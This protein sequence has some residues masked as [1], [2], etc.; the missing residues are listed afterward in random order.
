MTTNTTAIPPRKAR[1]KDFGLVP[2]VVLFILNAVDE[3]DRAVLSVA[4]EDIREDFGLNDLTVGLLPLAVIFIT[5][6]ISLPA[7]NWA[8]RWKRIYILAGGAIV[9][10]SAGILA[11]TSRNFLQLFLTRA[12]LGFGQGT[13]VP[14]HASLLS[15][16]YPVT[17]RG[18]ALSYHR[19]A[20]PLG[21]VIG[22][23]IGG[24]IVASL[25]WRWA[26]AAAAIPGLILGLYAL[27]LREPRRG[28]SDLIHAAKQDPLFA[29][30]LTDPPDK[31]GFWA[32]LGSIFR[33]PSLKWLILTNAAF[34]FPLF[35]VVFWLPALFEREFGATTE[36]AGA[37]LGAMAFAA[38]LGSWVGGPYSDRCLP[39]GFGYMG[40]V[41]VVAAGTLAVT[42]TL[43]FLMPNGWLCL[44]LLAIGAFVASAGTAGLVAIVAAVSPPRIRS[45]AFSAFGLALAVCGAAAAPV[46]VGGISELLQSA[47]DMESG[48]SLRIAM[49]GATGIVMTVGTFMCQAASR[50][51][52]A[53]VHKTMSEF[54]ADY[55]SRLAAS[56]AAPPP[57][58]NEPSVS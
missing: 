1:L 48:R 31:I 25:G 56:A 42:W 29:A 33:I 46:V 16:Y 37:A 50:T 14:T 21:Q 57:V 5:G 47:A 53:D 15:D 44:I 30:F 49:L 27:R 24:L 32:S 38:F 28:E 34:G 8:D 55:Q 22:A 3:F 20:N 35:G 58:S 13:I 40:K 36:Q 17:V 23:V 18:R 51:C 4:L 26:F 2:L 43:A 45:Q 11:A 19:S 39:R 41:G 7:G 6:T 10:G 54:L 52:A 12:L 9:W